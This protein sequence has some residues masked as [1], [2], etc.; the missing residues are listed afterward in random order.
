MSSEVLQWQVMTSNAMNDII[1]VTYVSVQKHCLQVQ[2]KVQMSATNMNLYLNVLRNCKLSTAPSSLLFVNF[3]INL[4]K[5]RIC[6][7]FWSQPSLEKKSRNVRINETYSA[8]DEPAKEREEDI[9]IKQAYTR[10]VKLSLTSRNQRS[11]RE[12]RRGTSYRS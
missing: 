5:D 4:K 10:E 3:F 6:L 8:T 12:P 11:T 7:M 2:I 1:Y 9:K